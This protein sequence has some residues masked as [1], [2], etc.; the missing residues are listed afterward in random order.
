[1]SGS[2]GRGRKW[3][4]RFVIVL[5]RTDLAAAIVERI[6]LLLGFSLN[7]VGLKLG[8]ADLV[9]VLTHEDA[10][11]L[12]GMASICVDGFTIS[13]DEG[14]TWTDYRSLSISRVRQGL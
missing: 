6:N 7:A 9:L 2:I 8:H 14:G 3:P 13:G 4:G 5:S 10:A 11:A 1:M 12:D